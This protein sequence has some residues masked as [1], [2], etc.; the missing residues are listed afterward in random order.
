VHPQPEDA[1]CRGDRD[2]PITWVQK[3]TQF[4]IK[5]R[6]DAEQYV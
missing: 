2:P 6:C 1:P 5:R 4:K 3:Y